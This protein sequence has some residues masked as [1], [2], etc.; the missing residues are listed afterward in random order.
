MPWHGGTIAAKVA[1]EI[2]CPL[3]TNVAA[4]TMKIVRKIEEEGKKTGRKKW[5]KKEGEAATVL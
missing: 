5:R 3:P 4:A 2:H 1:M